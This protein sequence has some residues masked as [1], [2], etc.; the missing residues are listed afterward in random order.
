VFLSNEN[1]PLP[2]D[3]D[4]RRHCVIYTPPALSESEYDE[5]FL[6]IEN[7]GIEAF[8]HHLLTLDL[9]DFHP[10]KR[11]PMTEAKQALIALSS[12]SKATP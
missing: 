10:K 4:D 8:Y 7:G 9:G 6:E 3:N 5:V 11:P 12:P 1:Q 2:L